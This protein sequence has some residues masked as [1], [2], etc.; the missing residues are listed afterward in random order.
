MPRPRIA[1]RKVRDILRLAWSEGLSHREVGRSL[2]VPFTT[3]ADHVRRAKMAGLTWPLA[4]DLDDAALEALLFTKVPAP[5]G[6]RR[7]LPDWAEVHKEL[8][9]PGVTLMLLWDADRP[10]RQHPAWPGSSMRDLV[11]RERSPASRTV[12][13]PS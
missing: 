11:P 13:M 8:R 10:A 2:G 9:R 6:D 12:E 3:V 7:P 4:D 5:P 1:M